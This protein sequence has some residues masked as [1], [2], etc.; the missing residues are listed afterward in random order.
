MRK[1]ARLLLRVALATLLVV[2]AARLALAPLLGVLGGA[3][4]HKPHEL[5][6][7]LSP[8]ARALID[9]VEALMAA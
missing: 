7:G 1:L 4:D 6:S 3:W 5:S 8:A 9:D 2:L